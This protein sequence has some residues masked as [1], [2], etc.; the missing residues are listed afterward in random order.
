LLFVTGVPRTVGNSRAPGIYGHWRE[1]P[2][3]L[4]TE[5]YYLLS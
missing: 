5:V 3:D 2:S 1:D 4:E